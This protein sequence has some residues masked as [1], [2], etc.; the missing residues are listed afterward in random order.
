MKTIRSEGLSF[1]KALESVTGNRSGSDQNGKKGD[2]CVLKLPLGTEVRVEGEE[3]PAVNFSYMGKKFFFSKAERE[4]RKRNFLIFRKP[5]A[6]HN[7][8]G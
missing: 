8:L 6:P 5:D 1:Q 4:G 3:A 7:E 2:F